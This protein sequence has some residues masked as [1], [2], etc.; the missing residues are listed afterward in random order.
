MRIDNAHSKKV[1]KVFKDLNSSKKGI[2]EQEAKTR[3][4]QYGENKLKE[5]K[6][7]SLLARFF[8]QFKDVM[9]ILLLI[10]AGISLVF[11]FVKNEGF[12]EFLDAIIIFTIVLL[13]ATLGVV[14]EAK[15]ENA[16][17][18]L[19]KMSQPYSK[20]IREGKEHQLYSTMQTGKAF[21]MQTMDQSLANL[22]LSGRITLETMMQRCVDTK[23]IQRL[24]MI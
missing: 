23:E 9:I 4:E 14:Q 2:T 12:T 7:K 10:S 5:A 20:V 1:E 11:G 21:G 19:K 6:K 15:A 8:A 13:N 3:L 17:D 24:T 16:M 22:Y 18:A